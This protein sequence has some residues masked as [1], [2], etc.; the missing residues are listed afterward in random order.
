MKKQPRDYQIAGADALWSHVHT[1]PGTNPLVLM[2]TGS[3]KSLTMAMFIAGMV[4]TYPYLRFLSLTHVKEL[5]AGN[6]RELMDLWPTAPAGVYSAGLG[7]KDVHAQITFAG[8][9]S[10]RRNIGRFG[11]ID[12]VIVD[13]AHR[14]NDNEKSGYQ[15]VFAELRN[16]N[17]HL[18]V[19]GFTA[20]GF[21]MGSGLLTDGSL[22]DETCFDLSSANAF[23]WMVQQRYLL[24]LVSK[25][26]GIQ[27]DEAEV[28]IKAGEYDE[29]S[30]SAA[31]RDQDILER[32]VDIMIAHAEDE[33]RRAWLTFAQSIDDAEL[34]ADM[35]RYKGYPVEAVHSKRG[36]RDDILAKHRRGELIGVVNKDVLTTGYDDPRIDL[37]GVLRLTRS[38]GLWVQLLG[39]GTRPLWT[40]GYDIRT[41]EGREASILASPKQNCRVLDFAGNILRLGPINYPTIPK[42]RQ[43]GG[44][45]PPVRECPECGTHNHISL[46][47]CEEC[48]YEFPVQKRL[49]EEASSQELVVDLNAL[50][51]PKPKEYGVFRVDQMIAARHKGRNGKTDSMRVDYFC[52]V[53][54][55]SKWVCFE[56]RGFPRQDAEGW[57]KLHQGNT[58]EPPATVEEGVQRFTECRKPY[59]LKVWVNA[60][61]PEIVGYDFEGLAFEL[62]P[63]LGG[64]PVSALERDAAEDKEKQR[65]AKLAEE[66]FDDEIPF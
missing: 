15:K 28:R 35:F 63:A 5:V 7:R 52:G 29:K 19:I 56:H 36:D 58:G 59:Y 10:I 2:P 8:I 53:R 40:P 38:P 57:W 6:Y 34:L 41:W 9:D 65:V 62:P 33:G 61:Y 16:R 43:K 11:Q 47:C 66:M 27:V 20:T 37:I 49:E 12:F 26:P 60:K 22:F 55:F 23:V 30:A 13:E 18:I 51:P 21:R 45:G 25:N 46:K 24:R 48:G 42:R 64:P 54:R 31:F 32:A 17:P 50:P 39:R 14:I 44:G 4:Q 3:G 1:K